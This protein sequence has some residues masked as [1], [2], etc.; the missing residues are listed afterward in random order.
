MEG[1]NFNMQDVLTELTRL[2]VAYEAQEQRNA[3]LQQRLA[4]A[5]QPVLKNEPTP[6]DASTTRPRHCL[7]HIGKFSGKNSEWEAWRL[8]AM[9]KVETDGEAIG[10][11][12]SQFSYLYSRLEPSA[13]NRVATWVASTISNPSSIATAKEF[14]THCQHVFGDPNAQR[15]ALTKLNDLRQRNGQMLSDYI[16]KFEELLARAGGTTWDDVVCINY[17]QNS[18]NSELSEAL[19]SNPRLPIEY[20]SF[21]DDVL[22]IDAQLQAFKGRHKPRTGG[23]SKMWN[24]KHTGADAIPGGN[25]MDWEPTKTNAASWVSQEELERRK[26]QGLC[27]RCGGKGHMIRNCKLKPAKRPAAHAARAQITQAGDEETSQAEESGKE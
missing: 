23:M 7:D 19:I 26:E 22:R 2:R 9:L 1:Q 21:K 5:E 27:L 16:P 8:N 13:Q 24:T 18:L 14:L 6:Q 15:N 10:D 4:I 25:A 3:D 12:R 17:L 20:Q 11:D